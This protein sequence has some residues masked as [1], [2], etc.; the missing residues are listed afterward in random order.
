MTAGKQLRFSSPTP[1]HSKE[2]LPEAVGCS[3]I[4]ITQSTTW[5]TGQQN[6]YPGLPSA[7]NCTVLR[8]GRLFWLVKLP[9]GSRTDDRTRQIL[10]NEACY[11]E[12][13]RKFGIHT[14][15]PLV[16]EKDVLFVPCFDRKVL[17]GRV[18][19]LGMHSLFA[20]SDIPGFGEAVRHETY[21]IAL[22]K[23]VADPARELREY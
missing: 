17:D 18:E 7:L 6:L 11:L 13:A 3:T 20:I 4:S 21:C 2:A 8:N 9:C 12:V 19:R 15:E 1:G 23:V 14:G 5:A 16:Y 10:R 22:A